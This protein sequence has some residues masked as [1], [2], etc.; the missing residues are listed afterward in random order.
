MIVEVETLD[1]VRRK[2]HFALPAERLKEEM[3]RKLTELRKT[4]QLPGF[5]PNRVPLSILKARYGK[6]IEEETV[7]S[8]ALDA[9]Q[10]AVDE[11]NMT[12]VSDLEF[13]PT[14]DDLEFPAEG[15]LRFSVTL[16]V[17]PPLSLPPL[18]TLSIDKS[19]IN[20]T[21]EDV[22]ERM[23]TIRNRRAE[24]AP[25]E[26]DRPA[27]IGDSALL[28]L[29]SLDGSSEFSEPVQFWFDLTEDASQQM[30]V[31]A[32]N[33]ASVGD[34]KTIE[35]SESDE[36][37]ARPHRLTLKQIGVKALEELDDGFAQKIGYETLDR[38]RGAV[39][40][41]MIGVEEHGQRMEQIQDLTEQLIERTEFD[42]PESLIQDGVERLAGE[43]YEARPGEEP[44]AAVERIIRERWILDEIADQERIE[45]S[46]EEVRRAAASEPRYDN[47]PPE[48]VEERLRESDQ[49]ES[50]RADMRRERVYDLLIER[51]G[52]KGI[53]TP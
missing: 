28:E 8:A 38:M 11:R 12:V 23:E 29:E 22:D 50:Y 6:Q 42:V 37:P 41:D 18:N 16:E 4:T 43:G 15:E 21:P 30:W 45:V 25:I 24:Y 32:V 10:E 52:Q 26:E 40:S 46:D 36:G 51:A 27:Q 13:E 19:P 17:K 49:W 33:G 44:S 9:A 7:W 47:I 35:G 39:W 34:E 20:V 5:R 1:A 53:I 3:D 14:L 31:E 48:R 2:L